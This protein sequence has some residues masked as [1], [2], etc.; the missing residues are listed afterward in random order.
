[1]ASP[2]AQE[3]SGRASAVD[4]DV[5]LPSRP[6]T[7]FVSNDWMELMQ[8]FATTTFTWPLSLGSAVQHNLYASF[9]VNEQG[10]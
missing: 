5:D 9:V 3:G 1:M 10:V 6:V 7:F 2:A 8:L 4:S